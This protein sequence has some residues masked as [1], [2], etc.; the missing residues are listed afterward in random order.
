MDQSPLAFEFL[1]G[2][3]YAKRGEKT[4]RL[5]GIKNG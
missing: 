2:K 4:M 3:T 5:K 1:K